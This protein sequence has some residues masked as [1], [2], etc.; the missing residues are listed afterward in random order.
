MLRYAW[1]E[2]A[3]CVVGWSENGHAPGLR[4]A[5]DNSVHK[6]ALIYSD[7]MKNLLV[8]AAV[9]VFMVACSKSEEPK[10]KPALTVKETDDVAV[11]KAAADKGDPEAQWLY[12]VELRTGKRIGMQKRDAFVYREKAANAGHAVAQLG[13]SWMLATGDGCIPDPERAKSIRESAMKALEV[14]A[15]SGDVRA[16]VMLGIELTR[17]DDGPPDDRK[18]GLDYL[19]VASEKGN[20]LAKKSLAL[21]NLKERREKSDFDGAIAD[22]TIA[23][24]AGDVS[25]AD[26]IAE[27]FWADK[28]DKESTRKW[29]EKGWENGCVRCGRAIVWFYLEEKNDGMAFAW[30]VKVAEKGYPEAQV[31]LGETYLY[32]MYGKEKDEKLGVDWITRAAEQEYPTAKFELGKL[33]DKGDLV[34]KDEKKA[35]ELIRTAAMAGY[36]PAMFRLGYKYGKGVGIE[37]DS[38]LSYAWTNLV[39]TN[40]EMGDSARKNRDIFE[41]RLSKDE[42]EEAQRLSAAWKLGRDI[43]REKPVKVEVT[44]PAEC[45]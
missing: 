44:T 18:R 30:T 4:Q 10:S 13:L 27:I 15:K 3:G 40:K 6:S 8:L 20:A 34:P 22:L 1:R 16:M 39:V 32:G 12:S 36:S 17:A 33:Y 28:K 5:G 37:V 2:A 29:A 35:F 14:V 25:A 11:I 23:F 45:Y 9:A 43:V 21:S 42:R 19:R 41:A 7:K 24:E 38:V 26:N 31:W